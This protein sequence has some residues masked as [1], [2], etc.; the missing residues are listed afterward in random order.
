LRA[1]VFLF[2]TLILCLPSAVVYLCYQDMMQMHRNAIQLQELQEVAGFM[3]RN[4]SWTDPEL[5]LAQSLRARLTY[6]ELQNSFSL[7]I[8][9]RSENGVHLIEFRSQDLS[10]LTSTRITQYKGENDFIVTKITYQL[11]GLGVFLLGFVVAGYY[12]MKRSFLHRIAR[13]VREIGEFRVMEYQRRLPKKM[14][15]DE[16]GDLW[17]AFLAMVD[18]LYRD[19]NENL[20]LDVEAS[21]KTATTEPAKTPIQQV[22]AFLVE[23]RSRNEDRR[24]NDRRKGA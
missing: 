11:A 14:N 22:Q 5:A 13:L 16:V 12:F 9:S 23:R 20:N 2:L 19:L 10:Q 8:Q 6:A 15:A 18:N 24:A 3:Q 21:S 1:K 7:W 17:S 4:N